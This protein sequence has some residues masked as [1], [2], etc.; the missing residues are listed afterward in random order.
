MS[1]ADTVLDSARRLQQAG[2]PCALVSVVK[3][4]PP[5]SAH[6]GDKAVVTADGRMQGWVGG[7]C[8]QPAVIRT[9][10][11]ALADG[12]ARMIRI[13]PAEEGHERDLG[14]VLEFGMACHSGGTLELFVDPLMPRAEL[15]VIG[16]SPVAA[17]L[18]Q[19]GPRV[20]FAVTLV[21]QGAQASDHPDACRV[22]DR[23]DA[24]TVCPQVGAGAWVVIATQGRRDLQALGLA[25]SLNA[26][27]VSFVASARKAQVLKDSLIT[28][29][30]DAAA[31]AAIVA[32]AGYP[33]SAST[34]EEI[35]LSVLAAVV[36]NRRQASG[37]PA[38]RAGD[39]AHAHGA[40]VAAPAAR[41]A[42]CGG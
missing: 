5:A 7:G 41:R 14:D 17:S 38:P 26:R 13:S 24:A 1:N 3:S 33:I 42:C 15:V 6:P 9:V 30:A 29:G 16:S 25:L 11:Q 23:D 21:A 2:T 36:A 39:E 32:P 35:A 37:P 34:P 8:A 4:L 10:R 18:V 20:G 40:T 12:R 28:A 22:I 19:L 31:V 27:Q